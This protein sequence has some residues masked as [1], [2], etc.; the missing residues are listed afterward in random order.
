M[1]RLLT[2]H[3]N[4]SVM[5]FLKQESA[6]N[7]FIIGD[8]ENFGYD[9]EFQNIWAEFDAQG[10]IRAVLLRY[11]HFYIPYAPGAFDVDSF[12][13]IMNADDKFEMM[14]GK[15]E[16]TEQ[17]I[18]KV[19]VGTCKDLYFAELTNDADLD[20]TGDDTA[21]SRVTLD[22]IDD[23]FTLRALIEEFHSTPS[24]QESFRKGVENGSSRTYCYRLDGGQMVAC[25]STTAENSL[26]AM[27][28]GVCTHPEYRRRG[29]ATRCMDALCRDILGEGRTLCLFYDNPEAGRIYK[30]MGFRDIGRWNMCYAAK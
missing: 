14:S 9:S 29:Y 21:V 18:G 20:D 22:D 10:T 25:A 11:Y 28:V 6:L 2:S 27:I 13:A 23:V 16:V 4:E 7:L 17:L 19:K 26:S 12:A 24:G 15:Q 3:D 5:A 8:I 30:R 1:I